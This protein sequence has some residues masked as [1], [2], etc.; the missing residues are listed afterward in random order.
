MS[1]THQKGK[2]KQNP[3]TGRATQ[4]IIIAGVAIVVAVLLFAKQAQRKSDMDTI[5]DI[6]STIAVVE[7]PAIQ[8]GMEAVSI[9]TL[10][11]K[12]DRLHQE[13]Q[14]IFVFFHSDNCHLCID[15]M[16]VVDE[17]FPEYEGKV[18]L[19]DVNVYD[20]ANRNLLTRAQIRAIPTQLFFDTQGEITNTTGLMSADQLR[21]ILDNLAGE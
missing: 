3:T 20:E 16:K 2:E 9:E 7:D 12:I 6:P 11:E 14:P 5:A 17:V 10:E 4:Y 8:P 18:N 19:V 21:E 15:M 13:K 1:R